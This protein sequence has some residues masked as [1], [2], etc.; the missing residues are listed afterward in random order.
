MSKNWDYTVDYLVA[1]T[2]V[3]GALHASQQLQNP[4]EQ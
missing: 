1:G 3:A 4:R 2:G